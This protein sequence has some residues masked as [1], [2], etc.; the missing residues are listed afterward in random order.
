LLL[1]EDQVGEDGIELQEAGLLILLEGVEVWVSS[2]HTVGRVASP[3]H[4]Q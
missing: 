2:R 4:V 1:L 3:R